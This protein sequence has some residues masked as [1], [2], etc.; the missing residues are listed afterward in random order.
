MLVGV[1]QCIEPDQAWFEVLPSG[2]PLLVMHLDADSLN[3]LPLPTTDWSAPEKEQTLAGWQVLCRA[4]ETVI[5]GPGTL[6][7]LV[8]L[9]Q[10]DVKALSR[11]GG[12]GQPSRRGHRPVHA[13][14]RGG[15]RSGGAGTR[16]IHRF[17]LCSSYVPVGTPPQASPTGG[18]R[19]WAARTDPPVRRS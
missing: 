18:A 12:R 6:G 8:G 17:G 15:G 1:P 5:D 4:T 7:F 19:R 13:E 10:D 11:M 14:P 3:Q 9:E 16:R 2:L